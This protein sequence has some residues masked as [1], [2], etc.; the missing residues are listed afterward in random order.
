MFKKEMLSNPRTLALTG[1]MTAVI[2]VLTRVIQ[3]PTPAAGYVHLGDAAVLFAGF[4]FGPFV[5]AVASG[6]GTALADLTSWPQWAPYTLVIHGLMGFVAGYMA[7]RVYNLK[8]VF[9][10]T[11][12]AYRIETR[13]R[14]ALILVGICAVA[15]LGSLFLPWVSE[16]GTVL[17]GLDLVKSNPDAQNFNMLY[18]VPLSGLASL[19]L[20]VWGLARRLQQRTVTVSTILLGVIAIV[21]FVDF[22]TRNPLFVVANSDE[23]IALGP[24][25]GSVGF[26]VALIVSLALVVI[27]PAMT[28]S[29][30]VPFLLIVAICGIILVVG[31]FIAGLQLEGMKTA[32]D[33]APNIMQILV[34]GVAG[35]SLYSAVSQAYPPIL[36]Y[37][38]SED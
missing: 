21:Y 19:A 2:F 35:V 32:L 7:Q 10:N 36:W 23:N 29:K 25:L 24:N 16:N 20:A 27:P 12:G 33:I 18:L 1:V 30:Y 3:I 15:T 4:A 11:E 28:K 38:D 22:F 14:N 34:G 6:L 37:M 31:Y 5:G 8:S 13:T 26:W 17:T 9:V